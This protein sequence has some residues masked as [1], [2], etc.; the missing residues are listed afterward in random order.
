[1]SKGSDLQVIYFAT[2]NPNKTREISE[3]LSGLYTVRDL[4]DLNLSEEIPETGESFKDNS[5]IKARFL[6]KK[7]N[8]DCFAD[9]SG[10][11]VEALDG[12]P[13]VRSARYAGEP[14]DDNRNIDLLLQNLQ[15]KPN[16]KARFRTVITLILKGREIQFEGMVSGIIIEE[17]RGSNGFGYDPVFIPVGYNRTF[18]EMKSEE[19]NRI[20]H[21]GKAVEKLVAY[22]SDI[23]KD[24]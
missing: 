15:N 3:L 1:M 23:S 21:R 13:G 12:N 22:L 19:K 7:F 24:L 6:S 4:N 14:K 17:R 11:E 20:S 9:D 5:S 10:L 18:G 16:R 2:H 8:I